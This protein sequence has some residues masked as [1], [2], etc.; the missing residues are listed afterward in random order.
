M[1]LYERAG[2]ASANYK[3]FGDSLTANV[4]FRGQNFTFTANRICLK[5]RS[6]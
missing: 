1:E 4:N 5:Y 6:T 3:V 2:S